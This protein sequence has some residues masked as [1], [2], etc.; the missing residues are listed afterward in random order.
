MRKNYRKYSVI[1]L[2][3]LSI[4]LS[5]CSGNENKESNSNYI[6]HEII[7]T[8]IT[9]VPSTIEPTNVPK[10]ELTPTIDIF[11]DTSSEEIE[12]ESIET[13][14]VIKE[15]GSVLNPSDL[16][17]IDE[18][19][20]ELINQTPVKS[21]IKV[22]TANAATLSQCFQVQ[23]IPVSVYNRMENKSYS[24]GCTTNLA[25]LRYV[26]VLHY[27]FDGEIHIGELVVN[28]M[29]ASDIVDIFKE[30]F[31]AKYPIEQIALVD[32]YDADDNASMEANNTSSF[33][34]RYVEGTTKL[35]KHAYGLAVDINPLY[36][37][38]V[39]TVDGEEVIVPENGEIYADRSMDC[40]YFIKKDDLIYKAFTER[41]FTWGGDWIN[42]KDYQHFQ[43]VIE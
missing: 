37:P 5:S 9:E 12:K 41:G 20:V 43:K 26:R 42:S 1:C 30:L 33:N 6:I 2:S 19:T 4:V 28:H 11:S 27:G 3:C 31:D 13:K 35:S 32:D 25:N 14:E 40:E 15:L 17:E 22:Y 36:N 10:I 8:T 7:P 21:I 18:E 24:E 38:Y 23:K 34:Y 39:H 16:E 29:I